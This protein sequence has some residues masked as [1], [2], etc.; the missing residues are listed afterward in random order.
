MPPNHTKDEI[1]KLSDSQDFEGS[2]KKTT[3]KSKVTTKA[4]TFDLT[5]AGSTP[6]G[7]TDILDN[8]DVAVWSKGIANKT[9]TPADK[10]QEPYHI[11]S[12]ATHIEYR[13]GEEKQSHFQQTVDPANKEDVAKAIDLGTSLTD[14]ATSFVQRSK[15]ATSSKE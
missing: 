4:S 3:E 15:K 10:V 2:K 9:N 1:E 7:I 5:K 11:K 6:T 8:P 13:E 14:E 12:T